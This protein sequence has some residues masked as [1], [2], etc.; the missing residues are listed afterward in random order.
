MAQRGGGGMGGGGM[1]GGGGGMG[2]GMHGGG[3]GGGGFRGG[4]GFGGS[5]GG[6]GNFGGFHGGSGFTGFRGGFG[7]GGFHNGFGFNR[8]FYGGG[9]YGG[10]YYPS[11]GYGYGYGPEYYDYVYPYPNYVSSGYSYPA[12]YSSPVNIVYPQQQAPTVVY[13]DRAHP[14]SHE[15]DQYGQEVNPG[16]ASPSS[17]PIYLIAFKDHEIRAATSYRVD[18]RTLHYMT[19]QN[20]NR[21][22]PL[23]SVDRDLTMQLNRERRVQLSLPQ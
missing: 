2:G 23:D 13:V 11:L 4:G 21:Q 8:G 15:Y 17:S 9:Y 20:E 10:G 22:A 6:G 7:G 14:V 3:M 12:N 5:H 19:L 16:A 18:G 1:R